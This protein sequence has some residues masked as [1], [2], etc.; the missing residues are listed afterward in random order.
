MLKM[1]IQEESSVNI[2]TYN[3]QGCLITSIHTS[4]SAGDHSI[5]LSNRSAGVYLY[6]I[7]INNNDYLIMNNTLNR[8][9]EPVNTTQ[10]TS[11]YSLSKQ[12]KILTAINDT[13]RIRKDGYS[14]CMVP[15]HTSDTSGVSVKMH[16][17]LTVTDADGNVYH[18]VKLGTQTWTV[19]NLKTTKFNDGT[20][21]P[22]VPD[23]TAWLNLA[24]PGYCW[25]NNDATTNK[26]TYGALYNWYAVN[27]GKLAPAGWHI[28]T[29]A[30]WDILSVYLGGNNVSGGKLKEFG[31]A[32]WNSPNAG[33][34]N[35]SG[36]SALPGG[37]RLN[38]GNFFGIGGYGSWWGA[39]DFGASYAYNRSLG[40][41]HDYLDRIDY[42]KSCG[43][44]VRLLR[45]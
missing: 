21:I 31:T 15:V 13:I 41:D 7:Q 26:A 24:T 22:L 25:Y 6:K 28:P 39:T 23:G 18:T 1:H 29:D 44:S 34:T 40:Y 10:G 43:F 37:C 38:D 9:A 17:V 30:E 32:H 3:L 35:E 45:D 12:T 14:D 36:F 19:E 4:L 27:T 42:Y 5:E 20:S 16:L 2:L 33:V 8:Y 11:A